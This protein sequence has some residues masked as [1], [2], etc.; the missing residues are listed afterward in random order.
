LLRLNPEVDEFV[1][2]SEEIVRVEVF[3]R[4]TTAS[5]RLAA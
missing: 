3:P 2:P 1:E 4:V 5:V